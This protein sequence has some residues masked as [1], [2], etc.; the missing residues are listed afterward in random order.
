[1][2]SISHLVSIILLSFPSVISSFVVSRKSFL[3]PAPSRASSL[4][5]A[6]DSDEE[7]PLNPLAKASWYAVETFG[8][9][10][11]PS[12][13]KSQSDNVS[14]DINL[15]EPPTSLTEALERIK[16]DNDRSYFLSGRVDT[17]AY[18]DECVFSDPFV[19]FAGRD[20]FVENLQNLGSFITEYDAKM[21]GYDVSGDGLT[22]KT[23]V[24]SC[25]DSIY[26][27]VL[28]KSALFLNSLLH[29][30]N[31]QFRSW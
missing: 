31:V 1:M 18:E 17:L 14:L 25:E 13:A 7:E 19:S 23:K 21:L 2:V 9:I 27:F 28:K 16:L 8:K 10:F 30:S 12:D 11:A 3:V 6:K 29:F 4:H 15:D 24:C 26:Y 5:L 20:R 22:V